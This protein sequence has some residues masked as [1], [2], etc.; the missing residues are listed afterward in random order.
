MNT[1]TF[2]FASCEHI[3]TLLLLHLI[4][5][6][7]WFFLTCISCRHAIGNRPFAAVKI[8]AE[9]LNK[10]CKICVMVCIC[11]KGFV[12]V[13]SIIY[14]Y[15]YVYVCMYFFFCQYLFWVATMANHCNWKQIPNLKLNKKFLIWIKKLINLL[16]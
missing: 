16:R 1:C 8:T 10:S 14:I 3:L 12:F 15:I 4:S 11:Y 7:L 6:N 2:Y 9:S 13:T 5:L